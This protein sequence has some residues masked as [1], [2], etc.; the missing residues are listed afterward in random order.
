MS[1]TKDPAT[2]YRMRL[3]VSN[4]HRY[5]ATADPGYNGNRKW[6]SNTTIWGKVTEELV[7]KPNLRFVNLTAAEKEKFIFPEDW[8]ISAAF[9]KLPAEDRN[10]GKSFSGSIGKCGFCCTFCPSYRRGKCAG[11]ASRGEGDC[12]IRDCVLRRAIDCCTLCPAFPCDDILTR[13]HVT[14]FD[15]E[16]LKWKKMETEETT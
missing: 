14:L 16:W 1:R 10:A 7:F 3:F 9:G 8:D 4:G 5:A 12:F 6:V 2:K 15:K 11:C 13:P